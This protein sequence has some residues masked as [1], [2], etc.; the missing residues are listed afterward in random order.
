MRKQERR[1]RKEPQRARRK[2]KGGPQRTPAY[3]GPRAAKE[4]RA[5]PARGKPVHGERSPRAVHRKRLSRA[6]AKD[7]PPPRE[8]SARARAAAGAVN[9]A[10]QPRAPVEPSSSPLGPAAA[11]VPQSGT[12]EAGPG[13]PHSETRPAEATVNVVTAARLL[14]ISRRTVQVMLQEGRL[15]GWRVPPRGWWKISR[16]ALARLGSQISSPQSDASTVRATP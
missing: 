14:G 9:K 7:S 13:E 16:E 8:P 1:E 4:L 11:G 3:G 2:A 15:K 10:G 6:K 5:R 12:A